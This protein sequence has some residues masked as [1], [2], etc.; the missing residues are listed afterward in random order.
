MYFQFIN[1]GADIGATVDFEIGYY[2]Y[3]VNI[4]KQY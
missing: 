1:N 3:D 4:I 2:F